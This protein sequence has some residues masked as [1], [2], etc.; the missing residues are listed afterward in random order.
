MDRLTSLKQTTFAPLR[1]LTRAHTRLR[2]DTRNRRG[3]ACMRSV[4]VR[5]RGRAYGRAR[6]RK[7]M[8]ACAACVR[9]Q[10]N[11]LAYVGT[12]WYSISTQS[13]LTARTFRCV[14]V[15][16]GGSSDIYI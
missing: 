2:A 9:P 6:V 15:R 7:R 11:A 12:Y 8:C 10:I 13:F 4:C 1:A 3:T 14:H 16:M 5:A